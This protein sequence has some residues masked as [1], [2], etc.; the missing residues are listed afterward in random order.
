MT[1]Y[2]GTKVT[3]LFDSW[4]VAEGDYGWYWGSLAIVFF[5]GFVQELIAF[6]RLRL[7]P[8]K[9]KSSKANKNSDGGIHLEMEEGK[10][11]E[12]GGC[13]TSSGSPT[14]MTRR[15]RLSS[16]STWV[17]ILLYVLHISWSY[18]LML[19]FMTYNGGVCISMLL[20]LAAGYLVFRAGT[21]Y[22]GGTSDAC[23]A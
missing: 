10:T 16:W 5:F 14:L 15:E 9:P 19:V 21:P 18:V 22:E 4:A 20:G 12:D 23:C 8:A 6:L 17:R 11:C 2:W 13:H 7:P 3:I 1:F